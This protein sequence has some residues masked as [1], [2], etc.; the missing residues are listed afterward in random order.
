MTRG[1]TLA[2]RFDPGSNSLNA[3]RLL[4]AG[5]VVVQHSWALGLGRPAPEPFGLDLGATAVAGFFTISGYLISGSRLS[6]AALPFAWKRF[7]RIY[8]GYWVAIGVTAFGLAPIG[9][10]LGG[11]SYS[12]N[13]AAHFALAN[14]TSWRV[15]S[16]GTTLTT[17]PYPQVWNGSL[18]TIFFEILCYIGIGVL[19]AV[20]AAKQR[21]EITLTLFI[22]ASIATILVPHVTQS[23]RPE[24]V[25]QLGAF[26]LAGATLRMYRGRIPMRPWIASAAVVVFLA[27]SWVG[28]F[29]TLAPL[30]FAYLL[31]W[32]GARLPLQSIGRRND[33]SYGLYIYAFP[34]QQILAVMDVGRFGAFA[35]L[36]ASALAVSPLAVASWWLI[37]KP[38]MTMRTVRRTSDLRRGGK[39][40]IPPVPSVTVAVPDEEVIPAMKYIT[41]PTPDTY[42]RT[43][44]D[45]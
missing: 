10:R 45:H 38:A 31:L 39:K 17:V 22:A 12:I 14:V 25:A 19:Y 7:L 32:L 42:V 28:A 8:P 26:A 35:F 3:I 29:H 40:I 34:V 16:I 27:L 15:P 33:Y 24:T 18:W 36:V 4:L 23:A 43:H 5:L 11:G 6:T 1:H 20:P 9:A 21:P 13:S 2:D 30:P 37:E 41:A 44:R